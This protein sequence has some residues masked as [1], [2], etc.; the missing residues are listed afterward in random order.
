MSSIFIYNNVSNCDKKC[1]NEIKVV[2]FLENKDII[3]MYNHKLHKE[4]INMG[5]IGAIVAGIIGPTFYLKDIYM[6]ELIY[7]T[8]FWRFLPTVAGI[9][10]AI[11]SY[12]KYRDNYAV[13]KYAYLTFTYCVLS[14]M[15]GIFYI[16]YG[17]SNG[18]FD[19][20]L[21]AGMVTTLLMVHLFSSP[22]RKYTVGYCLVVL[23]FFVVTIITKGLN[24]YII[25]NL[26][27]PLAIIVIIMV[28]SF[29]NE[30]KSFEQFESK[31]LLELKER[32]LMNEMDYRKTIEKELENE[33]LHDPLTR[34]Y[35][36]RAAEKILP[37]KIEKL[38][39]VNNS[40]S[41]V[42]IDL[43][44]L[45]L[46]NDSYGHEAGD[47]YIV[48]FAK[49]VTD[50]MKEN[51]CVFRMG[52]DEFVLFFE[53]ENN[54]KIIVN[55]IVERCLESDIKFSYGFAS[56]NKNESSDLYSVIREADIRMYNQKR[57]KKQL[58]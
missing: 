18:F 10:F 49:I 55:S 42:F 57:R 13:I 6:T 4:R 41:V 8:L 38:N 5:R 11:L 36:R 56:S 46:I 44:D 45:K 47:T 7:S 21:I 50:V 51:K 27:N 1:Y 22:I 3:Q 43:D 40:F 31:V 14:M 48:T 9:I 12:S 52:G 15:F 28:F 16:H 58:D 20:Y 19:S 23:T 53:K 29:I 24:L 35:N 54:I 25:S 37:K 17:T 39:T 30:K 32:D 2:I 26:I 34:L 33:V